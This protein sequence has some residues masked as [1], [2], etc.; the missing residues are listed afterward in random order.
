MD[1][2]G[3]TEDFDFLRMGRIKDQAKTNLH[4]CLPWMMYPLEDNGLESNF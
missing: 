1:G 4:P 2:D 3:E